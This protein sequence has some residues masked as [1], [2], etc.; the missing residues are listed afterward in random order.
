[1]LWVISVSDSYKRALLQITSKL[2]EGTVI[3]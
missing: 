1:M 2:R 3:L